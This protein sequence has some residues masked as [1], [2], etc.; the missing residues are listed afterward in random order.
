MTIFLRHDISSLVIYFVELAALCFVRFGFEI[1]AHI[2]GGSESEWVSLAIEIGI[3][4]FVRPIHQELNGT[5]D[6]QVLGSVQWV[7]LEIS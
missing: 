3:L 2:F 5:L 1:T 6:T 4:S 7:L